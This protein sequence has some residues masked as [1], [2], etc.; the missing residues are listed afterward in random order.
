MDCRIR[1]D[2]WQEAQVDGTEARSPAM[3]TKQLN[4][5]RSLSPRSSPFGQMGDRVCFGMV[6]RCAAHLRLGPRLTS[7]H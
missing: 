1:A 2:D 7:E 3:P 5:L 4:A 6:T